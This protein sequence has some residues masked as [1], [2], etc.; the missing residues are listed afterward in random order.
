MSGEDPVAA[1]RV[2]A[3][4]L[5]EQIEADLLDLGQDL[6]NAALVDA[7]FRGLHTLKGSGAMFG[8]DA[9]AAFTHHCE[10]AFDRVRKGAAPASPALVGAILAARD[11][12][13]ALLEDGED[14]ALEAEGAAIIADLAIATAGDH[15]ATTATLHSP[16][17][18]D[19]AGGQGWRLRFSLPRGALANGINPLALLDELRGLGA[20]ALRAERDAIPPLDALNPGDCHIRW[21]LELPA[22]VSRADID[23]VFIFVMDDMQ[24]ALEPVERAADVAS[25]TKADA[26]G[27]KDADCG[28]PERRSGEE[29]GSW[30]ER[31]Q[32]IERRAGGET[33]RVPAER[34]DELMNRVGELVITQ[35]RLAQLAGQR[36]AVS[37]V[38]LR[39]VAEDIERLSNE[40]R[41]TTMALRMMPLGSLFGRFRRLV[42]DLAR[43]TGK[44][45]E[46]VTEGEATE[47]DKTVIER[48]ADPLVHLIRNAC[49]HGIEPPDIRT[50]AGK[51]AA[52][53]IA[54]SAEQ[55]G[56]EVVIR[57][58]DNGRGIDRLAVRAKAEAQ[59]LVTPESVLSDRDLLQLIFQPGFSTASAVTNLSGRGVGMDVVKKTIEALRGSIEIVSEQGR[60]AEVRLHLPL[61]LAIVECMFVRIG[62]ARYALPLS[63]VE[64]CL[65]LP[66]QEAAAGAAGSGRNF[67][68]LRGEL[69]PYLRMRELFPTDHPTELYPKIVVVSAAGARVGLVVDQIIGNAQTVIKPLS[70]FHARVNVFAG[71]TILGDGGV[72]LILDVASLLAAS[73]GKSPGAG[74]MGEAA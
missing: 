11:H 58:A 18:S 59:G 35:S 45:I 72:A 5:L 40:L 53:R 19:E 66:A 1:F 60:G 62:T 55:V 2:E 39:S 30:D 74:R 61:T 54:I 4:E 8:F 34:L 14:S 6:D 10:T 73:Q 16:P 15:T 12:M 70:R 43:E 20:F 9:L 67:V 23:D 29:R 13:R 64:E 44:T 49:D 31:R 46:Y 41:D 63:A 69:V 56:G 25:G 28:P 7:V 42:H 17:A 24:L 38:M 27:V 71:A 37:E 3:R 57:I 36:G 22:S 51:P 33:V 21:E 26:D 50:A 47:V 68:N 32:G 65:E 52:G 48:I